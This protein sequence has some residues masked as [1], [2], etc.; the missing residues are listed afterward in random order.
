[1]NPI[2]G[3]PNIDGLKLPLAPPILGI[4]NGP[5]LTDHPASERRNKAKTVHTGRGNL[6]TKRLEFFCTELCVYGFLFM[7]GMARKY[8]PLPGLPCI[9][10][11]Q[12][13][14]VLSTDPAMRLVKKKDS[15]QYRVFPDPHISHTTLAD[16]RDEQIVQQLSRLGYD[17][18][19]PRINHIVQGRSLDDPLPFL[20]AD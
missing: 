13:Q 5:I 6:N 19:S 2:Q 11:A 12:H 1:M 3:L 7:H 8:R 10:R 16:L 9:L 18:S 4:R 15:V 17:L 14:P 20:Q